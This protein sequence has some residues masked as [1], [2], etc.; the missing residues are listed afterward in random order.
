MYPNTNDWSKRVRY[1]KNTFQ[2]S[3][4]YYYNLRVGDWAAYFG[5]A[6]LGFGGRIGSTPLSYF[7]ND[8][9]KFA[10]TIALYLA[11]TFS[12]NNYFDVSSDLQGPKMEK[13][14]IALG[15][16]GFREGLAQSISL[17][18][19]GLS[20][21]YL[22][23][24]GIHFILYSILVFL[25]GAYSA[26]PL[27][28]KSRPLADIISHGLFGGVLLYLYGASIT[29]YFTTLTIIVGTSLFIH[30]ITLELQNH[31][32]DFQ[33]DFITGTKTTA[34]W[35]GY[36]NVKKLLRFL[37]YSHWGLLAGI[38][39][40]VDYRYLIIFSIAFGAHKIL[41][42]PDRYLQFTSLSTCAVYLLGSAPF[43][44]KALLGGG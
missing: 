41:L 19:V 18:I 26:P 39:F 2:R 44:A 5:M 43:L 34:C 37:L 14:P 28:F 27:R 42:K 35:I 36:T 24:G 40:A 23:F 3:L 21:A 11:F 1:V 38:L 25:G 12:I 20:L 17:A 29:G 4:P 6:F 33:A 15:R 22:W 13:N 16:L 31:L 7:I 10:I 32:D 8:G 30:S 9:L